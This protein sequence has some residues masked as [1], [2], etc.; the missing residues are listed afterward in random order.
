MSTSLYLHLST[1]RA[2]GGSFQYDLN[3]LDAA[4][5]LASE[6]VPL[7]VGYEHPEWKS[8]IPANVPSIWIPRRGWVNALFK[9]LTLLGAPSGL[10][11]M[12]FRLVHPASRYISPSP[13]VG[14]FF[15]SQESQLAYLAPGPSVGVVHDLMH[16]Y[17]T[18]FPEAASAIRRW[19]RDRH[20]R[21]MATVSVAV[22]VDS[23][24]GRRQLE[25]SYRVPAAK[26]E[27][28]PF[29]VPPYAM[30]DVPLDFDTRYQL[31]PK[32]LFYPATLW[33][34]KNH[35]CI[36]CAMARLLPEIPDLHLV[37]AGGSGNAEADVNRLV[38]ELGLTDHVHRM[39][40]VA[41]HDMNGFYRRAR[42]MVMASFF[43]PTNI[44]PLEAMHH[45]CPSW[46]RIT[47]ECPSSAAMPASRS[48]RAIRN[49]SR[50]P[51]P[52]SGPTTSW[53]G[54]FL[55]KL[56]GDPSIS[57][58]RDSSPLARA[59]CA[60]GSIWRWL[61]NEDCACYR[62]LPQGDGVPRELL[63]PHLAM[64]GHEVHIISSP[65]PPYYY[66]GSAES[67]L[68][69]F[70]GAS[71]LTPGT[72]EDYDGCTLHVLPSG[73]FLR[74]VY[75]KGLVQKLKE[76]KPD[77]V[78][79]YTPIGA[80]ALI[81]AM[82]RAVAPFALFTA[83]HQGFSTFPL[84]RRHLP[85]YH[86]EILRT[87]VA[88][89]AHGRFIGSLTERCYA[90]TADCGEVAWRFFGVPR[91]KVEVVHLGSDTRYFHPVR[92][93]ED[94]DSRNQIRSEFGFAPNEI[95]CIFTGKM[96][97][98]RNPLLLARV[99]TDLRAHGHP[100]QALFVGTGQQRQ[101]IE[102]LG[103]RVMDFMPFRELGKFY[104]AADLGVWPG[105]ESISQLDAAGCGLPLIVG[106]VGHYR[107]HINGNGV[108]YNTG[109]EPDLARAIVEMQDRETRSR[110]GES[111]ANKI[112]KE[113]SWKSIANR[114]I[115]DYESAIQTT[116][117]P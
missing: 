75:L 73:M 58:N 24:M 96:D 20:F 67:M 65:L 52:A 57:A 49:N 11:R 113:F 78:Q 34:H 50:K 81:V 82:T 111:G 22:C 92:S 90:V 85:W 88:R 59:S 36:L 21:L 3:A 93:Q 25:E 112:E 97:K 33:H 116:R 43:G 105:P 86:P 44:P 35:A 83:N 71:R 56:E 13:S 99:V 28:L 63:P 76:L 40:Y 80:I 15:S 6:G 72:N 38:S 98:F 23:V 64:Q 66:L 114:R 69:K 9:G 62:H 104:R 87:W 107:E 102:S 7:V 110:L 70:A 91:R 117:R 27:V 48:I 74:R 1:G 29:A 5:C 109:D 12:L 53:Q 46:L 41:D 61:G 79:I 84:A 39:G 101:E 42:A 55:K 47:T 17:E 37:L 95:V 60:G 16:R 54:A 106:D 68:G 19:Y 30:E 32:F 26:A 2:N 31:P 89:G 4:L 103:F 8:F 100:F 45:G 115:A 51:S 18:S 108:V 94:A 10:L 14:K 77:V